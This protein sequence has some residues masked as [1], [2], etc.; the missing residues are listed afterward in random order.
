MTRLGKLSSRICGTTNV[1]V[2]TAL[3]LLGVGVGQVGAGADMGGIEGTYT[4]K[5]VGYGVGEGTSEVLPKLVRVDCWI[6]DNDGNQQR[7]RAVNLI[8]DKNRFVGDGAL[9]GMHVRIAG[10]VDPASAKCPQPHLTATFVADD[11]RSGRV[12]GSLD[13]AANAGG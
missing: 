5:V 3:V 8:R 1:S 13:P 11:A 9:D 6:K 10:R 4:V 7:L 2:V 12:V